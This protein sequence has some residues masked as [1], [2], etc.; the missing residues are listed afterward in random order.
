M[1]NLNILE[2]N[3]RNL[4]VLDKRQRDMSR[5]PQQPGARHDNKERALHIGSASTK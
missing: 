3:L 4:P 1:K 2:A 5:T